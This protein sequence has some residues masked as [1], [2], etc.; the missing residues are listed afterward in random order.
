MEHRY[1]ITAQGRALQARCLALGLPLRITR[2]A[3]GSG[4]VSEETDLADVQAL[5]CY[6]SDAAVMERDHRG[7]QLYLTVSYCNQEHPA[8]G[9]FVLSEIMVYAQ[10]PETG[11]ETAWLYATLGDYR[12]PVPPYSKGTP[13]GTWRYPMIVVISGD[14]AVNI[15]SPGGLAVWEDLEDMREEIYRAIMT[16]ELTLPLATAAGEPLLTSGG[17]PILAVYHPDRSAGVLT[18]AGAMAEG[19]SEGLAKQIAAAKTEAV[20]AAGAAADQKIAAHNTAVA[21]HPTHLSIVQK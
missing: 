7:N 9:A 18:A 14:L 20:S 4:L 11:A 10:D 16:N 15:V 6:V 2:A 1:K 5:L 8:I 3:V 12:Q 19:L 13:P 21:S 17:T